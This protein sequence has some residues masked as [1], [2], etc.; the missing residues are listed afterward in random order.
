[1]E[2]GS[3]NDAMIGNNGCNEGTDACALKQLKGKAN[4]LIIMCL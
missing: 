4:E 3:G 1:M 2:G